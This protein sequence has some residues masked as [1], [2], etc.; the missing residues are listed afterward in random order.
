M[1]ELGNVLKM[2]N[3]FLA[4]T[5]LRFHNNV[6]CQKIMWTLRIYLLYD[7]SV[8]SWSFQQERGKLISGR[9]VLNIRGGFDFLQHSP[10][11][12]GLR[13]YIL[14]TCKKMDVIF[15]FSLYSAFWNYV[16]ITPSS[17]DQ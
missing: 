4:L 8:T 5:F 13:K 6:N 12:A 16:V 14:R 1:P 3:W 7:S 10:W 11:H 17:T 2:I 15:C 9:R